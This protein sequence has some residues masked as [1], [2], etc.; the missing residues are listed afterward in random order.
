M[1]EPIWVSLAIG[2]ADNPP[3]S[4]RP[5]TV[6]GNHAG[7]WPPRSVSVLQGA[8]ARLSFFQDAL[9]R[10]T[11]AHSSPAASSSFVEASSHT[12]SI[13]ADRGVPPR[14]LRRLEA[15]GRR[16]AWQ[17]ISRYYH[18]P[19]LATLSRGRESALS[20]GRAF[21][22]LGRYLRPVTLGGACSL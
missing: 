2:F 15:V 16:R 20:P 21:V 5:S 8:A 3:R 11:E 6:T 22:R 14:Y 9:T 7:A 13:A 19:M 18:S 17:R 1:H 4:A 12:K 10:R